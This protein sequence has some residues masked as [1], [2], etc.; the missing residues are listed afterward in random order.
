M[1]HK[2]TSKEA[3]YI[4][5]KMRREFRKDPAKEEAFLTSQVRLVYSIVKNKFAWVWDVKRPGPDGERYISFLDCVSAGVEGLIV[6]YKKYDHTFGATF[7][8]YATW[9]IVQKI[10]RAIE[11][12]NENCMRVPVWVVGRVRGYRKAIESNG[13]AVLSE[14]EREEFARLQSTLYRVRVPLRY[15]QESVDGLSMLPTVEDRR[16]KPP[17]MEAAN[18]DLSRVVQAIL[19]KVCSE[20]EQ[21]ILRHRFMVDESE[22]MTLKEL[23]EKYS[24]SR[25]RIRQIQEEGLDR[26]RDEFEEQGLTAEMN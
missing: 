23:G 17:W 26:M 9:W 5:P 19:E 1:Q 24:L 2:T 20:K 14:E 25:E 16:M 4:T 22:H 6:A 18:R 11:D 21:D 12:H 13:E 10:R 8:T 15:T 7:S 3:V